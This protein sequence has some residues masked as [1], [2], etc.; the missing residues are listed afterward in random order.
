MTEKILHTDMCCIALLHVFYLV[1]QVKLLPHDL[2]S[3]F[4]TVAILMLRNCFQLENNLTDSI[5]AFF[6]PPPK[7]DWK[8]VFQVSFHRR[9]GYPSLWYRNLHQRQ[10]RKGSG[11][12][13][14]SSVSA[15]ALYLQPFACLDL[16]C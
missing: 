4:R 9:I 12:V 10:G 13:I 16:S 6:F 11:D 3:I 2:V 7:Q 5:M 15:K 8:V 14:C 1:R